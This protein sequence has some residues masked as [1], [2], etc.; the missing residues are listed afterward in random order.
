M[1]GGLYGEIELGKS[2]G[3][4]AVCPPVFVKPNL[5]CYVS[6]NSV[7]AVDTSH[8]TA[9]EKTTP[10]P[11]ETHPSAEHTAQFGPQQLS[12][13]VNPE[14]HTKVVVADSQISAFAVY[15]RETIIA[16]V[17]S[18]S[19]VVKLAKW[20]QGT[21]LTSI[22]GKLEAIKD[23]QITSLC[24]S[25]DG[26][27]LAALGDLPTYQITIWHWR[28]QKMI[29][30]G[31]NGSPASYI[32][33]DPHDSK[34]LC[35]SGKSGVVSFWKLKVG[36]KKFLLIP[37]I[38]AELPKQPIKETDTPT[39][40]LLASLRFDSH[41]SDEKEP[42]KVAPCRHIWSPGHRVYCSS[43]DGT[44]L[45]QFDPESGACEILVS[46]KRDPVLLEPLKPDHPQSSVFGP[47]G[48]LLCLAMNTHG[49]ITAGKD[50]VVRML[51]ERGTLKTAVNVTNGIPIVEMSLSPDYRQA[52]VQA[53]DTRIYVVNLAKEKALMAVNRDCRGT[54]AVG[55]FVLAS[56]AVTIGSNGLLQLWDIEKQIL[57]RRFATKSSPS[58]LATSPVSYLVGV[59]SSTGH[60]RIYDTSNMYDHAPK[61]VFL[62]KIHKSPVT[63]I[64]FES[65]G[66]YMMSAA[67]D[68]NVFLYDVFE[69]FKVVGYLVISG[70]FTGAMW[71]F[72]ELEDKP[73]FL[74]LYVLSYEEPIRSTLIYRF[75]LPLDK[76]IS[77]SGEDG[78][79]I[80]ISIVQQLVYKFDD[81][82]TDIAILPSH[83]SAGRETFYLLSHERKLKVV[84]APSNPTIVSD[85]IQLGAPSSEY[86]DHQ[87]SP[88]HLAQSNTR[89]WLLT[90]APDGIITVRSLLE[91][92]RSIKV[93]A[94]DPYL[95]GVQD[96]VFSRDCRFILTVGGDGLFR[97]WDWKYSTGGR[98]VALEAADNAETLADERRA[99]GDEISSRVAMIVQ[100]T[101]IEDR[102]DAAA[103]DTILE[104]LERGKKV[105]SYQ[106]MMDTKVKS[107]TDK[108]VRA[109]E[110]NDTVPPLEQIDREEFIVDFEERDR[111]ISEAD[112][113][114]RGIRN[115]IEEE[116]LKKRVIRN[117][118][119]RECWDSMEVVGQAIKSFSKETMTNRL[120]EV[121]NYPIRKRSK[122]EL[123]W[124][125]KIKRLR[126]VQ[127]AVHNATMVG[128]RMECGPH[129]EE[130]D[131][132]KKVV[133]TNSKNAA[134]LYDPF[135][136]TTNERRRIQVTLLG[137]YILDIK[138]EYNDRFKDMAKTKQDEMTKIEEKNERIT[139]I[140]GQL[141]L[142]ESVY[143]PELDDDE[144]PSRIIEVLDS[145]VKIERFITAE[146]RKRL[147]E[148][149]KQEEER[150]R[151]N[152]ED[153]SRQRALIT[154]QDEKVELVRP[155][156]MNKPKEE[157]S[158]DERKQLKEFEKKMAIFKDE[159][160]KY[161]KALET[162]LRKL[163]GIIVEICDNYD[164]QL[165]EFYRKK[166]T[167]D[168]YTYQCELRMIKLAQ[169]ALNSEED[170]PKE[171][172][173]MQ[174]LEELKQEKMV[175]TNEIP[176]IKKELERYREEYES[177]LKRDKEVER[178]FKKE[179][180][181]VDFYFDA[182]MRLF[183]RRDAG[184]SEKE[185]GKPKE[186][187]MNPFAAAER[188]MP[189]N[190]VDP[191]PLNQDADMPEGLGA[192]L[193]HK[194]VE[195]RDKKIA[196]EQEV[197]ATGRKF[198]EMQ[199]LVE[200]PQAPVV[201][202]YTDAVLIHRSVVEK[203]NDTIVSLGKTKVDALTE[204]KDYRKGIHALEWENRMLDFQ[205][206]DL[207]IRTRDI[208][209]LRV[210]KQMQEFIRSGDEHK[211]AS[212]IAALEK[213]AEHSQ[214]AHLHKLEEKQKVLQRLDGKIGKKH[215]ENH[216]LETHLH[217][218]EQSVTER[219]KISDNKLKRAP[220]VQKM[221]P[222]REIYTR[223]R[224]IDLAKSQAQDIA[225][226]REEVERLRLRTYPAFQ[227]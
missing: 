95:G 90:W 116:N 52:I 142:Q 72:E 20:G 49:F 45:Y 55:S 48:S 42:L 158:D 201:T 59:G 30:N 217:S 140:L 150:A 113:R 212:E 85:K 81:C 209:L 107:I 184:A 5:F 8:V 4:T 124:I 87:R 161:R 174:R 144:V 22:L 202:D 141:Q 179:F 159:Q 128:Y 176:E 135:E 28:T 106:A 7:N 27:Y 181:G 171:L 79:R 2:R 153:N 129:V 139:T 96:A 80:S 36:F 93:Y 38:G 121:P 204:M 216:S 91:P 213:R 101:P 169:A 99:I 168:Q 189:L 200:V 195:L 132:S 100:S 89:E 94:H 18:R 51:D 162:E 62:Q 190:E 12:G 10:D 164:T 74:R 136:L 108:L 40:N 226:L 203:L 145:E 109:M 151:Q 199:A 73:A 44:E 41:R 1:G 210:T 16:F 205:A 147:E 58:S 117:R 172:R 122:D 68:G 154:E 119:K 17:E 198:N 123:R 155:E 114:I 50:G 186:E 157:M 25:A 163:Q 105:D 224:L 221:D 227:A 110:K 197:L 191:P 60:V 19:T 97:R 214:K 220:D 14:T 218:L 126:R 178:I 182:L 63:K 70:K 152:A 83:L 37:T 208:Q 54:L 23:S 127:L 29:S 222:L 57:I 71:H 82:I 75:E 188:D 102:V 24:F 215:T 32:S 137:E 104:A 77:G 194:L 165:R 149:R 167:I 125:E 133:G 13:H 34:R 46:S 166:L 183:K 64:S 196:A 193:W 170:E 31:P 88:A 103:E 11:T 223:R 115:Q 131:Q 98:R 112:A 33:F 120:T 138:T 26:Q 78:L 146:E 66:R 21:G 219:Q 185:D 111:L 3:H 160:E 69:K 65:G 56:K 173:I 192:D 118:I 177:A 225:I 130:A 6:G 53:S 148:K 180:H 84:T 9:L 206:D 67:D 39:N 175:C 134:L 47:P 92:E 15:P 211:Q 143:H 187:D 86:T 61:L 43:D 156:W 207:V 35:T 76:E